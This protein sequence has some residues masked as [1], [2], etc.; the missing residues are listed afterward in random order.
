MS[1]WHWQLGKLSILPWEGSLS[2]QLAFWS[3]SSLAPLVPFP[4]CRWCVCKREMLEDSFPRSPLEAHLS[5]S[6]GFHSPFY[7]HMELCSCYVNIRAHGFNASRV[8][9]TNESLQHLGK[10]MKGEYGHLI[11]LWIVHNKMSGKNVSTFSLCVINEG[12]IWDSRVRSCLTS[13]SSQPFAHLGNGRLCYSLFSSSWL[14]LFCGSRERSGHPT[15]IPWNSLPQVELEMEYTLGNPVPRLP[16]LVFV[17]LNTLAREKDNLVDVRG[18]RTKEWTARQNPLR[19]RRCLL[20]CLPLALT[21]DTSTFTL[22]ISL[23]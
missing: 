21:V 23:S 13:A 22:Q 10:I 14:W 18:T 11:S 4:V 12:L 3:L 17:K 2:S 20:F 1:R 15:W 7:I 9:K 6:F 16:L 19:P 5:A 8:E